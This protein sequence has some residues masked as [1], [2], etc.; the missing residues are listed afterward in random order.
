M[1]L[2]L[3]DLMSWLLT[4][5]AVPK[6]ATAAGSYVQAAPLAVTILAFPQQLLQK[7]LILP[8]WHL[9]SK[10]WMMWQLLYCNCWYVAI[11]IKYSAVV[12]VAAATATVAIWQ[13]LLLCFL[14]QWLLLL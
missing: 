14:P 4:I 6:V 11:A 12:T 8:L 9:L 7:L 3:M 13:L 1:T 5:A 2:S 10:L